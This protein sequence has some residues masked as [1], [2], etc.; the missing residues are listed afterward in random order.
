MS[1]YQLKHVR[2]A[3]SPKLTR[4]VQN[5]TRGGTAGQ[6]GIRY[7][8]KFALLKIGE[9]AQ[10]AF[11]KD[12]FFAEGRNVT[13]QGQAPCF[14]DDLVIFERRSKTANHFQVKDVAT[15]TWGQ[16][17]KSIASDF[18]QQLKL[19]KNRKLNTNLFLV[20]SRK[21]LA[22]SLA[23]KIPK[24]L[25]KKSSVVYFPAGSLAVLSKFPPMRKGLLALLGPNPSEDHLVSVGRMLMGVWADAGKA[26]TLKKLFQQLHQS[27]APLLRPLVPVTKLDPLLI[28]VF[29]RIRGFEFSV[30]KGFFVWKYGNADS[31]CFPEHCGSDR[32]CAFAQR[33]MTQK[34]R[35]FRKLEGELG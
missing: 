19:G 11:A 21:S 10:S 20:V 18:R 12:G 31:G 30:E 4:Y 23:T 27:K 3:C 14:V 32:F 25:G 35:T 13:F 1:I 9:A 28:S 16:G 29:N 34:P 33:M 6:K 22:S 8:D 26:V 2:D 15:L 17:A 24:G 7:E 5:K